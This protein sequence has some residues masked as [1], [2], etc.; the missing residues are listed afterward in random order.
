MN[1]EVQKLVSSG[2]LN[3]MQGEKLS[4]LSPGVYCYHKSWGAGKVASWDLLAEEIVID[5]EGRPGHV[6]K[7]QFATKSLEPVSD[8]HILVRRL[9]DLPGL[10]EM[11]DGQPVSLMELLVRSYGGSMLLDQVEDVLKDSVVPEAKYRAWWD[12]TKK[13]LRQNRLFVV[14]SKRNIPLELRSDDAD[15][16]TGLLSDFQGARELKAKVVTVDAIIKDLEQFKDPEEQLKAI[17]EGCNVAASK[18][19][20]LQTGAALELIMA[21]ERLQAAV[22]A[23]LEGYDKPAVADVLREN[24]SRL[25]LTITQLPAAGQRRAYE[26][27]PEAFGDRWTDVVMKLTNSVGLRGLGEIARMVAENGRTADLHAYLELGI[28]QRSLGSDALAWVCKERNRLAKDVFGPEMTSAVINALERDHYDDDSKKSSKLQDILMADSVLIQDLLE[29]ASRNQVR[30]FARR[31]KVTPAIEDLSRN[32]LLARII[33]AYPEI[34]ELIT[35]EEEQKEESD[36]GLVVS[37]ES[38]DKRKLQ[39]EELIQKKIPENTKEIALARS[40]GDLRENF[41]FKAA[42]DMQAVLMRQKEDMEVEIANARGTDFSGADS[43]KVSIGTVVS[44]KDTAT[45]EVDKYAILGAWDTDL[46]KGIIS[47]LSSTS[48]ALL[49]HGVGDKVTLPTEDSDRRREVIIESIEA[50][51]K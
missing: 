13:K 45:G 6:L 43:S 15:L 12:S 33:K 1:D 17:V 34:Q 29:K 39:L 11:A 46:D 40:Y 5:F 9:E 2:K 41:E 25:E 32:S 44:I 21:R 24:E 31:L 35:G 50:Y 27:F 4:S 30:M 20:R 7:L 42:K 26:A 51:V 28:Q 8:D 38:L 36:G 49:S 48:Q 22:P 19:L 37:W 14:P 23:L 3:A 18:S 47:Y 16:E 10:K